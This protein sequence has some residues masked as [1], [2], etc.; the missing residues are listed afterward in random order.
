[1]TKPRE[2]SARSALMSHQ[3]TKG[4][5]QM[6]ELDKEY[7]KG[8]IIKLLTKLELGDAAWLAE[9]RNILKAI[10]EHTAIICPTSSNISEIFA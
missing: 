9:R 4:D 2:G 7:S 3:N 5:K 6:P 1:M 10:E 8:E